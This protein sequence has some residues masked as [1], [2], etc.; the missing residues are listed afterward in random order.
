ME[1][2]MCTDV[3]LMRPI[4]ED[5][6]F[7]SEYVA[8]MGTLYVIVADGMGG[9]QAGEVA[10]AAAVREVCRK[11]NQNYHIDM[12]DDEVAALLE[13]AVAS[14]NRK[15]YEM[16][17]EDAQM[18]GMGTTLTFLLLSGTKVYIAHVGDSRAYRIRDGAITRLTHDHSMVEELLRSGQITPKQA[19]EH[20]QKNVITRAVG[21]DRTVEPDILETSAQPGD[22]FLLCTDGLTNQVSDSGLL[23]ILAESGS[24]Q[25]AANA[26]VQAANAAGGPD[27][28]TVVLF[29]V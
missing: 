23:A 1:I 11:I 21:T 29:R 4:N 3:G 28:S 7:V 17:R 5:A 6:Y 12:T 13:R 22:I 25:G 9:H 8:D 27:N 19:M 20:P 16:S 18:N 2:G 26:M 24:M 14:A 10:S 15:V